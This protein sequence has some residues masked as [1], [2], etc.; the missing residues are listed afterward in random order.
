MKCNLASRHDI[1]EKKKIKKRRR[2]RMRDGKYFIRTNPIEEL[3][4]EK[5]YFCSQE[6]V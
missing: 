6:Q 3:Q 2:R 1:K 5:N 4:N